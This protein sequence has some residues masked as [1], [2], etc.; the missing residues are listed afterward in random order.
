[1]ETDLHST[2]VAQEDIMKGEEE[3]GS[4]VAQEDIMQGA[5]EEGLPPSNGFQV[6]NTNQ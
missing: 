3:E 1:M 5:E 4:A 6:A 2:G